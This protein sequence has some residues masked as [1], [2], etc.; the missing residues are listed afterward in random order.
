MPLMPS[1]TRMFMTTHRSRQS[2][3]PVGSTLLCLGLLMA[4]LGG[5]ARDADDG[6]AVAA[7][8]TNTAAATAD[9]ATS[10]AV[11]AESAAANAFFERAFAEQLE[12][13]PMSKS[14]LAIRDEDYD[15]WNEIGDAHMDAELALSRRHLEELEAFDP[16][17][18]DASTRLSWRL[19]RQQAQL[20]ID[21]H[22]WRRHDYLLDQMGGWQSRIATFL[23]NVHRID[24]V[25]HAEA[26]IERLRGIGP[27]VDQIIAENDVRADEGVI[28]P[29]FVWD[30]VISD[31]RNVITGAPFG[32]GEDSPLL[33]DIRGKLED[34]DLPDE[35]HDALLARATA[36]LTEVVAPSY[37]N[38]IATAETMQDA[39][40][41]E[42][43]V[44]K[45]PDGD[46]YYA[47]R[48]RRMTTTDLSAAEIHQLG[49]DN[50]AR[51]HDEMRAIMEQ[52]GFDGTLDD[53][54]DF[55]R[56]D[57]QFYEPDTEAGRAAYLAL[58]RSYIDG[59]REELPEVF[60]RLPQAELV[61]KAVEPFRERSAGKAFYQRPAPDGSR[62]GTYYANLYRMEDMPLYQ[63]EALA[64]HEAIPGHHMQIA[65]AQELDPEV[66][67][68]FRR[69]GGYTAYTEGWG[70]Y[71]E[72]LPKELGFYEDPYS[73]FGRLAMEL[74]RAARLVVDTGIHE[75]R[76]TR[77]EAIDYLIENTPNP[78]GDSRKAIER[79]I[80][81]PGQATAYMIGMLKILEIREQAREAL[82]EDFDL[83]EFH[84]A[85]LV[86][87]AVPL[88][89]L[90][91][92]VLE[93]LG[94]T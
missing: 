93:R 64:Y 16:E 75:L 20:R 94:A 27:L 68:R 45:L 47:Y 92:T 58:A 34:L 78:P 70:L 43:G 35:Q 21:G 2:R 42:D 6:D 38:L 65:I 74:W 60:G 1:M 83:R 56:T 53:F 61:V 85:V 72:R 24:S 48:L 9:A 66:V 17:L 77:E 57:P 82:G 15:S 4:L 73:D 28:A 46:A 10:E 49:L 91:V 41:T 22:R 86:N 32:P 76:W 50:V 80:V 54:F 59:M 8:D 63:A 19:F 26:Y 36:A 69:F 33:T 71:S 89:V 81:M 88:D 31:A 39:A 5:C 7:T 11:A 40:T 84:D 90:E 12:L 3:R 62:P 52:V 18:L 37:R 67:P 30:Y 87:G 51:I 44:W 55:M 14:Y 79:Y 25:E 13:N 29:R 23:I